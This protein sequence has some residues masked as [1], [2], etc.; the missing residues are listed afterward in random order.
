MK[1]HFQQLPTIDSEV[2]EMFWAPLY[3]IFIFL[4]HQQNYAAGK[5]ISCNYTLL[6]RENLNLFMLLRTGI[7]LVTHAF[8]NYWN[9][10]VTSLC[11]FLCNKSSSDITMIWIRYFHAI[12]IKRFHRKI[13]MIVS[14]CRVIKWRSLS[15]VKLLSPLIYVKY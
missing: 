11:P 4:S 12:S 5:H 8:Y 3:I 2:L 10:I 7:C 1:T 14:L 9:V 15:T 13:S 6:T